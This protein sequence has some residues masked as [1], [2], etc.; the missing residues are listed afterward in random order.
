ML[1]VD[2]DHR[3]LFELYHTH[4][5][6]ALARWEAGSGAVYPLDS[7]L[8]RPD[9]WTSADAAGLAILPG[10]VRYDEAFGTAPIQHAFR[11]TVEASN[12]Y[13]FPASHDAGGTT[14]AL[15]MGACLRLKASKDLSSYPRTLTPPAFSFP[16][17]AAS[18]GPGGDP[19]GRRRSRSR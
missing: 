9:G 6:A 5:N 11:F 12:H 10:L 17:P 16:V 14:G 15:P 3:L 2:R 7:N 1:I 8:R 13:V 4:W 19:R 18:P